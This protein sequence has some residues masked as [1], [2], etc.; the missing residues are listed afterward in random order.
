M[1][2]R[3]LGCAAVR[4]QS[5]AP[6]CAWFSPLTGTVHTAPARRY[7]IMPRPKLD[8]RPVLPV[9]YHATTGRRLCA[10]PFGGP[11]AIMRDEAALVVVRSG[12]PSGGRPVVRIFSAAGT[13]L[14]S[15]LWD[16]GRLAGWGWSN[17]LELMMVDVGGKVCALCWVVVCD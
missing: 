8:N 17:D 2:G 12:A 3:R 4:T 10:A 5:T 11:M 1:G 6:A 13:L 9:F 15:L 7:A 16:G 14:G